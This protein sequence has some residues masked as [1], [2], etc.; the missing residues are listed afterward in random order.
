MM[1]TVLGS[2]PLW[3][4]FDPSPYFAIE[5]RHED[6]NS[7]EDSL[8]LN[9]GPQ[10][11]SAPSTPSTSGTK[12]S[13]KSVETGT[14]ASTS[15]SRSLEDGEHFKILEEL[16]GVRRSLNR[17]KTNDVHQDQAAE[18]KDDKDDN[19]DDNGSKALM[20]QALAMDD[21]FLNPSKPSDSQDSSGIA[22]LQIPP[23]HVR[24]ASNTS[25]WSWLDKKKY[26]LQRRDHGKE[27]SLA[28]EMGDLTHGGVN[29]DDEEEVTFHVEQRDKYSVL[30]DCKE[31]EEDAQEQDL[32]QVEKNGGSE[33]FKEEEDDKCGSVPSAQ[34]EKP[35]RFRRRLDGHGLQR[36]HQRAYYYEEDDY[37]TFDLEGGIREMACASMDKASSV[38]HQFQQLFHLPID[39]LEEE[40]IRS[41]IAKVAIPKPQPPIHSLAIHHLNK[42]QP[43]MV[44]S[45]RTTHRSANGSGVPGLDSCLADSITFAI[46]EVDEYDEA[47]YNDDECLF[48][49]EDDIS[50]ITDPI[51]VL[52]PPKPIKPQFELGVTPG[53]TKR[54]AERESK[55]AAMKIA[56]ALSTSRKER[57]GEVNPREEDKEEH[58]GGGE[59]I[60]VTFRTI[61]SQ[62]LFPDLRSSSRSK[63]FS[64]PSGSSPE[65]K[66]SFSPTRILRGVNRKSRRK[67]TKTNTE[68]PPL[69]RGIQEMDSFSC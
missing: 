24:N 38:W 19:D 36:G 9:G 42:A 39:E 62:S 69:H 32:L 16:E 22:N 14:T 3:T 2:S 13:G 31:R 1:E 63:P 12:R 15:A 34:L 10:S 6:S 58:S 5:D 66:K 23:A 49:K 44:S 37:E 46:D 4:S 68:L 11:S 60:G 52:P 51:Y 28:L 33:E 40:R 50:T 67:T 55:A 47:I 8:T 17:T 56:S 64:S 26:P 59:A 48:M 25:S 29:D 7:K 30:E 57:Q 41:S 21:L 65:G 45:K 27:D 35:F 54:R 61:F 43:S 20:K 18:S 53:S